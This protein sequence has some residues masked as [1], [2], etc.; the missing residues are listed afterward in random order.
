MKFSIVI[1]TYNHCDD[2]LK[3]CIDSVIAYSRMTDVE[4]IVSA[5]GCTDNTRS[6]LDDLKQQFDRLGFGDHLK[7]VWHDAALGF[8]KA[9][10]AGI[11]VSTGTCVLLL[12]NDVI[13]LGQYR[14][15]WL[16]RL[17]APFETN[18]RAGITSTL[19]LYSPQTGR[20]FAVFFCTLIHRK[21]IDKLGLLNEAYGVGAGEDTEY[22]FL[23]EEAG[24]EVVPVAKTKYDPGMG[25]NTSDFPIWHKAEGTMHDPVLVPNWDVLFHQNGVFLAQQFTPVCVAQDTQTLAQMWS[26]FR[27]SD[28]DTQSYFDDIFV[29]NGYQ[30]STDELRNKE[31]I[32]VGA[33]MGFFSLACAALGASRVWSV[34]PVTHTHDQLCKN[35]THVEL[36]HKIHAIQAAVLGK[37]Q[38]PVSMGISHRHGTSSLYQPGVRSELVRVI[39]LADIME[40]TFT[41]NVIL[42]MDCEGA[43]YDILLDTPDSVFDR[44]KLIHVQIHT[45]MHPVH[46]QRDC[47]HARL[48]QLGFTL[49]NSKN[50][51]M[52]WYDAQGQVVAWEPG[53]YFVEIWRK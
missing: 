40:K 14:N 32:D 38:D 35:I 47:L 43:E 39:S 5:N 17:Y 29:K 16:D 51:G 7:V 49:A 10:N 28:P 4:L 21:V 24:F 33:N 18:P 13:L 2:L 26:A 48:N 20:D 36:N 53:P 19:M 27:D 50:I 44:I 45:Q 3:P 23:A 30:L 11:K 15:Q 9:V 6:Y 1:P 22:C 42:K 41:R 8:S 12:N 34:E 46:K 37:S 31:V 52:N 25:T